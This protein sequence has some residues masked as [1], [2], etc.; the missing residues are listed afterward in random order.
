MKYQVILLAAG[1]GIRSCLHFNKVLYRLDDQT[2]L[3]KS[4][5]LFLD[6][7]DCEK[8]VITY[9][10][11]ENQL[12]QALLHSA[13]IQYVYGGKTRQE[14]VKNALNAISSEYVFIHDAA[15]PRFS[16]K[17]LENLK[18]ELMIHNCVIPVIDLKDTIK[19]VNCGYV[20]ETLN[21]DEIKIVQTPQ[22]FK[23]TEI[24]KAH[25]IA[26]LESYTDDAAMIEQILKQQ[27]YCINGEIQNIKYTNKEDFE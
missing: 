15:R 12:F 26:K 27:V 5:Q 11:Q 21:R 7:A 16:K 1:N 13:K 18:N 6:D 9:K 19:K 22:G 24:K 10:E 20:V 17:L 14:S 8:V 2:I 23:T 25:Q 4:I 3:E